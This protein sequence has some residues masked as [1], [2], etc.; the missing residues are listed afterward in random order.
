[1]AAAVWTAATSTA[2]AQMRTAVSDDYITGRT[3][4]AVAEDTG[5]LA[6]A[7]IDLLRWQQSSGPAPRPAARYSRD[8]HFG[9]WLDPASE[10]S[11]MNIRALVLVRESSVRATPLPTDPCYVGTGRW[12]DPYTG[13]TYTKAADLQ[14][15]HTVALKN[16]YISGAFRWDW[17]TRCAYANFLG[18]RAHLTPV[19]SSI[20]MSKGDKTP[21]GFMPP[22]R[23]YRCQ[24]LANWLRVKM[25]WR[26]MMSESETNAIS[27]ELRANNC[28]A[29]RFVITRQDLAR[30]RASIAAAREECPSSVLDIQKYPGQKTR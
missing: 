11:C 26:L 18:D 13:G 12:L 24:Y 27:Q 16:A 2:N 20:N 28:D 25:I 21:A 15:D 4:F 17:K 22:N 3:F 30:V 9:P 23:A 8:T 6:S 1:M 29:S 10:P 14:V 19:Q 7:P 5:Q